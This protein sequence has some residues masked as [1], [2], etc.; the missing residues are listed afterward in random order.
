MSIKYL[1]EIRTESPLAEASNA[2]YISA[3]CQCR[4]S[5]KDEIIRSNEETIFCLGLT[6][7]PPVGPVIYCLMY[8]LQKTSV[9]VTANCH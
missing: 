7:Q 9:T 6:Q 5:D 2:P 1:Y 4:Y 3:L 8:T